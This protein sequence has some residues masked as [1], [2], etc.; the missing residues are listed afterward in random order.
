MKI[1]KTVYLLVFFAI[2]SSFFH[3]T[4]L[5]NAN[6]VL[7]EF[8]ATIVIFIISL[9]VI[10]SRF[11]KRGQVIININA[12]DILVFLLTGISVLIFR[13]NI[14][15]RH[16]L[17]CF[18]FLLYIT[19]RI[20]LSKIETKDFLK[21]LSSFIGMAMLLHV[22][23]VLLQQ[24]KITPSFHEFFNNGS[25]FGNPD[26]LA[27]YLA[28]LLPLV[29]MSD[30]KW[31]RYAVGVLTIVLFILI[32]ARTALLAVML[33]AFLWL[34]LNKRIQKKQIIFL[35]GIGIVI[36]SVLIYW[37]PSSVFGRLFVWYISILMIV[38][39]PFG[40]GTFAFEKYY[41]EFQANYLST[42][43]ILNFITP[44]IVHSPFNEF[45]NIGV[46]L[47]VVGLLF[48]ISLV[49]LVFYYAIKSKS[50]LLYPLSVF[51]VISLSYFPFS[52]A[53]LMVVIIPILSIVAAKSKIYINLSSNKI[54][55]NLL[56]SLLLIITLFL[57][58]QS[59]KSYLNFKSWQ[60]VVEWDENN[61]H[62]KDAEELF[63]R[64]YPNMRT[65]GRFLIT[66]S[67]F[68][69]KHGNKIAAL[70]LME[71][72][73]KYFCDIISSIKLA[74]LYAEFGMNEKAEKKYNF[75][76][77]LAPDKFSSHYE[78]ILFV[79]SNSKYQEAYKLCEELYEKPIKKSIYIDPYIIKR[80]VREF[81]T[82][83]EHTGRID[84]NI[85]NDLS[86]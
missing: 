2:L 58:I 67:N 81:I 79:I 20:S 82:E 86:Q 21:N 76:I 46:T 34:I 74:N 64:L 38:Q 83:Y 25:T 56:I 39:K 3:T 17:I 26:M 28:I 44:D 32:Q 78:K 57:G 14:L 50:V 45:L 33:C 68:Q 55:K 80:K 65:N 54:T 29:F 43:N 10:I 72:S 71:E 53:P 9:S 1:H 52:I 70:Q 60:Q 7:K 24:F 47:G 77:N 61:T 5:L 49:G 48:Y 42:H 59:I 35:F 19:I 85:N 69:Y 23:I 12:I 30:K 13:E 36:L 66:Y 51:L 15:T 40:W 37:Y 62:K 84:K 63:S 18:Y 4:N 11:F 75:A 27:S 8:V 22:L 73:E 6:I 31:L 16:L 41:P